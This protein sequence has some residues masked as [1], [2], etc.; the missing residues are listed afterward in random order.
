M[1]NKI[2]KIAI[3]TLTLIL[4]LTFTSCQSRQSGYNDKETAKIEITDIKGKTVVLN[5]I[6]E[7]IVSLSPT[8]TEIMFALGAGDKLV[9]VTSFCDYPEEAKK[10]DKIGDFDNPSIELIKKMNPDLVL[11]GGYIQEDLMAALEGLNI[12]VASTEAA[13]VESIY[14]S[15]AMVGKL[16][17]KE[18]EAEEIINNIHKDIEEIENKVMGKER[19]KVFYLVWKDPLYT[20]GQG[21]YINEIIQIA[22]GQNV[23]TEITGWGQYS[24]E[25]LLKQNP[26]ILIAAFHST[27]EGMR[28]EDIMKDEL[29]SKL[30]CIREGNI[31]VM[32]D[33]NIVSRPGPRVVEAIREMAKALHSDSF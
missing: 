22:G 24:F 27:D 33:D 1:M 16:V 14:D 28:K 11:A 4:L 20:A 2:K 25:E 6:P 10:I 8:N 9:G 3:I 29:F 7:R 13:D 18:T 12:P 21:T 5:K 15:I 31:H 23:A 26:D 19:K 30:P 32:S 17:G